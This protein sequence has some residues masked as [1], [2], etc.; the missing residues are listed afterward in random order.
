MTVRS[1]PPVF[2]NVSVW[3]DALPTS[4]APKLKLDGLVIRSP[5]AT[6]IPESAIFAVPFSVLTA[7]LLFALPAFVGAK[8]T[9]K[10]ALFP[11]P[12]VKGSVTP[13]ML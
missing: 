13:L 12:K 9:L 10:L 4:S 2:F 8:I 11:T 3:V 6:P 1:A 5:G 7:I